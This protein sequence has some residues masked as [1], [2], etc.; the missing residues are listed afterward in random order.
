MPDDEAIRRLVAGLA[1]PHR[2]GGRTIERAALLAA[3]ADFSVIITWIRAHGGPP[4]AP[5]GRAQHG[6]YGARDS[7]GEP[8]PLRYILP[9][10]ALEREGPVPV[11]GRETP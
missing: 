5:A 7:P 6:L 2:S 10:G 3:G 11:R 1:R 8:T 4:E 9:A